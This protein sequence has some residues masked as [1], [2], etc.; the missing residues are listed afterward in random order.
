MATYDKANIYSDFT[1]TEDA[2]RAFK[3]TREN[4]NLKIRYNF[5]SL[6][7]TYQTFV[8]FTCYNK[9]KIDLENEK[10]SWNIF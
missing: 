3:N 5:E 7:K 1:C 9:K 2:Y 6:P 8:N 10:K 4:P